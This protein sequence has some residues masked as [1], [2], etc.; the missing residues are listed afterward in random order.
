MAERI[1]KDDMINKM[2]EIALEKEIKK[3]DILS[4]LFNEE[5]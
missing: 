1:S 3:N 2:L 4:Y 5:E